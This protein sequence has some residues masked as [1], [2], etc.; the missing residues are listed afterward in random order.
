MSMRLMF[1]DIAD[2]LVT[3]AEYW[4]FCEAT[5][6]DKGKTS[7]GRPTQPV[8]NVSWYDA[9]DYACWKAEQDGIPWRLPLEEELKEAEAL[10][11]ADADFSEWP[12]PELPD[13]GSHP[14]TS[15][16]L[17]H[18]D[19]VGV[20][21]QWTMRPEDK[22]KYDT[23]WDEYV[24]KRKAAEEAWIREQSWKTDAEMSEIIAIPEV[25]VTSVICE[26]DPSY[27]P[28]TQ[29]DLE[30]RM[31]ASADWG[32][33]QP[34]SEDLLD[35]AI[36]CRTC[37]VVFRGAS[38]SYAEETCSVGTS[39]KSGTMHRVGYVSFRLVLYEEKSLFIHDKVRSGSAWYYPSQDARYP[40]R[41]P[42]T[43]ASFDT[44]NL[45]VRL[46]AGPHTNTEV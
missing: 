22:A 15:N 36:S 7:T 40:H 33:V 12:L 25:E 9:M 44:S 19:L 29:A 4:A 10:I 28:P 8:V 34:R 11:P 31:A 2:N 1:V 43:A 41:L 30:L 5:G 45:G 16:S 37:C 21:Y 46:I 35:P 23:T 13:V 38:W 14:Q 18:N 42:C 39:I 26:G 17:G 20:V 6:R 32:S 27:K 3:N 24:Q